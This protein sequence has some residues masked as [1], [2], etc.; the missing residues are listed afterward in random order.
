MKNKVILL[1]GRNATGEEFLNE[2]GLKQDDVYMCGRRYLILKTIYAAKVFKYLFHEV[3]D[4]FDIHKHDN[5]P[6]QIIE[7]IAEECQMDAEEPN[8]ELLIPW[9]LSDNRYKEAADQL[10]D[11]KMIEA[12]GNG[13]QMANE[14]IGKINESEKL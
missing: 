13:F 9:L 2:F 5:D 14:S 10:S 1:F 4:V 7:E 12:I 3:I 6:F 8:I 11:S